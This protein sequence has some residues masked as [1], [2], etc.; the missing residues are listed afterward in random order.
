MSADKMTL[1]EY[2]AGRLTPSKKLV[3]QTN[4]VSASHATKRATAE[5]CTMLTPRTRPREPQK[6][7]LS[8]NNANLATS[9][10]TRASLLN[11]TR[12]C[13]IS[14]SPPFQTREVFE[15]GGWKV[16]W[17]RR[18]VSLDD[19]DRKTRTEI[20]KQLEVRWHLFLRTDL[21]RLR[22]VIAEEFLQ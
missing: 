18:F 3:R 13:P 22:T 19:F 11:L 9:L 6:K 17:S 21:A 16:I 1:P 2:L 12:R 4:T 20:M 14:D 10:G 5:A 15:R 8:K 7:L